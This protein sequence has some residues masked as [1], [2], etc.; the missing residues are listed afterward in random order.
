M[1][2]QGFGF[3]F[4]MGCFVVFF[5]VCLFFKLSEAGGLCLKGWGE[6]QKVVLHTKLVSS[7]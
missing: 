5:C 3:G 1:K 4:F 7:K 6:G 2:K